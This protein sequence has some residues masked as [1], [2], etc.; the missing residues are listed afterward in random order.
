MDSI[1]INRENFF[2]PT[3][4]FKKEWDNTPYKNCV[5]DWFNADLLV[6]TEYYKRDGIEHTE[7]N[8]AYNN[9]C[10][11]YGVDIEPKELLEVFGNH[12]DEQSK[13][14]VKYILNEIKINN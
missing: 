10:K 14:L 1:E 13:A 7:L 3:S 6:W 2:E 12:P 4:D 11:I 5:K 8:D 9:F